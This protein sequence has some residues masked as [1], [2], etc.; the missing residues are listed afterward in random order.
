MRATFLLALLLPACT[1]KPDEGDFSDDT[2]PTVGDSGDTD[3]GSGEPRRV[4]ILHT[5]DWQSHM[6]GFGPNA[7]YTPDTTGDDGTVGGLARLRTFVDEVRASAGHPVVLY[8]GGD[9]MAGD[10][11]QLLATS[12]AAELTTMGMIEYDAVTI[13]NH[14][15]DWGPDVLGR[16]IS[17]AD[18]SGV[19]VPIVASN[20][21][22]NPDDAGDDALE[23][24]L[25][26]GRI[27]TTRVQELDNGLRIGLFGLLGDSAQAITPAV[28]PASFAP[29]HEAAAD[30]MA[31][32]DTLD[33]DLVVALTHNGVT[34]DPA[35]SPD[36][37]LAG[38]VPGIDV[39]VGGHSHTPLFAPRV[40]GETVIVQA[41]ALTQYVGE[42]TLVEGDDGGW[43]VEA[44][45]L[46]ELDDTVAGDAD[47]TTAVDG[48]MDALA[49]GPLVDLGYDFDTPMFTIPGDLPATGCEET[50]LGNLI[51]DAFLGE[52]NRLDP[53][54]DPIDFAFE[55][56]GVI[57]DAMH[58]GNSGVQGFSD[59]FRV[60]PLGF[61]TDDAPGYA[62]VDFY[63]TASELKDV[64]EVSASISPSYGCNYYIE[65]AGMRCTVE[66]DRAQ[67]ARA[68]SI[69]RLTP[70][71]TW[72]PIDTSGDELYHVAVD[73]YVASLMGILEGLTYGLIVITAKDADGNAYASTD[74]MI[75]DADPTTAEVDELKLWEALVGYGTTFPDTSGDGVPDLPETYLTP[76]GRIVEQ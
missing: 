11:F 1:S 65:V 12:H 76:A 57:R 18:A 8:D 17:V 72:E 6:L 10:L 27:E 34:D 33:V 64:C 75:F 20:I 14:E 74:E 71:G 73:S 28:V 47:V 22:P 52:M 26:S 41:G 54:G 67:F 59:V 4:T 66:P 29:A 56:Q 48:Y 49:T 25:A 53:D 51:T 24:H 68:R 46:H 36:D 31:E 7:E 5:N 50:G 13:G 35:T 3:T 62:L 60:L 16:M 2:D 55:S 19:T 37:L 9:W 58:A 61:G 38:A 39:I 63:V 44:Y 40:V 70:E 30:A 45:T 69:D 15:F 32:L 43:T 21:V 42:L 23:A